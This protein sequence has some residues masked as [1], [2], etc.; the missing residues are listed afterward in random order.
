MPV[1]FLIEELPDADTR[2]GEPPACLLQ[3]DLRRAVGQPL[4]GLSDPFFEGEQGAGGGVVDQVARADAELA[5]RRPEPAGGFHDLKKLIESV[6]GVNAQLHSLGVGGCGE[7][8]L[9]RA[10]VVEPV[11]LEAQAALGEVQSELACRDIFERVRLVDDEEI[12]WK[13]E[14]VAAGERFGFLG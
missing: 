7:Q 6:E 14:A 3:F 2:L 11:E 1:E 5:G 9:A 12:I 8:S 4:A 10:R 13:E